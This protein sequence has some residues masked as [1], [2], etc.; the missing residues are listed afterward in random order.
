MIFLLLD[1]VRRMVLVEARN[2]RTDGGCNC[3]NGS[4][5][6]EHRRL[7]IFGQRDK[8]KADRS[9]RRET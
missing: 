3:P 5:R 9:K 6:S 2:H 8:L 1:I 4:C 7:R